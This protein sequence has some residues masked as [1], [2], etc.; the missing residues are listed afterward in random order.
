MKRFISKTFTP[1]VIFLSPIVANAK[2]IWDGISCN[3]TGPC[4]LCDGLKLL[5]NIIDFITEVTFVVV[6]GMIILGGLRMLVPPGDSKQNFAAGKKIIWNAILG[7]IVVLL[8]W[9]LIKTVIGLLAGKPD[10]LWTGEIK[11]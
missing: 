7:L 8:A 10:F 2:S 1:T 11:C 4:S 3:V 6:A 5:A 9:L